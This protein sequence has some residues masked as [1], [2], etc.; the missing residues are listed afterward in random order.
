MFKQNKFEAISYERDGLTSYI[1]LQQGD[2]PGD[3][4]AVTWVDV[5]PGSRQRPHSH[6]P[7]QVYVIVKGKGRM[8]VGNEEQDVAEGD[9]GSISP[10]LL[11]LLKLL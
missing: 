9:L 1:L 5:V 8:Q 7:E 4:L 6:A 11:Q 10:C 3:R 2:L